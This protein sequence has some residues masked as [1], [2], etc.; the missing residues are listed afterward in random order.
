MNAAGCLLV[1]L[2]HVLSLGI[3]QADP[4]AWQTAAIYIPWLLAGFVTPMFL[5][6]GAIKLAWQYGER[7][8]SP[9]TYFRYILRRFRKIYIPYA[10]WAAVYYLYFMR[11]HQVEGNIR[12]FICYLLR[13]DLSAPFYYVLAVMQFYAFMPLWVWMLSHVRAYAAITA[14]VAVTLCMRQLA[15]GLPRFGIE[16]PYFNRI[17]P[18]YLVF[19][20][21]GLYVGKHYDA[22]TP[23][24]RER[25]TRA[26]C[27][28]GVAAYCAI[29]YAQYAAGTGL[30]DMSSIKIFADLLSI[31]LVH[32]LALRLAPSDGLPQK[33]LDKVYPASFSV[34]LSHCL[35]L[36]WV[37][38]HLQGAGVTKLS[39]LLPAR[40][41]VCYT[42]PFL[43][44]FLL[45]WLRGLCKKSAAKS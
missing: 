25:S 29:A 13:G 36:N 18:T 11:V 2:I 27:V 44:Y 22:F 31:L 6:T 1:I 5:Y 30:F 43:L 20:T 32:A 7:K 12:E 26:V 33:V 9:G 19:W 8:I 28:L 3:S 35:F 4:A 39:V 24:T 14:S 38:D 21:A 16:F 34:Y 23:T 45:C 42:A 40:F 41:A 17:F 15:A 10:V 37:T